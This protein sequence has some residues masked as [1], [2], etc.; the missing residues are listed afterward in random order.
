MQIF[1]KMKEF[2]SK[3]I[4]KIKKTINMLII[5]NFRL[6]Y[7]KLKLIKLLKILNKKKFYKKSQIDNYKISKIMEKM[8]LI[9][10]TMEI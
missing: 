10:L 4:T 6:K 9:I 8:N 3:I 2:K 5:N 1:P 7:K